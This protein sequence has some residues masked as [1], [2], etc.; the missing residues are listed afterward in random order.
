MFRDPNFPRI[1][2]ATGGLPLYPSAIHHGNNTSA[3]I[4][5]R[6]SP[7]VITNPSGLQQNPVLHPYSS[8]PVM[9]VGMACGLRPANATTARESPPFHDASLFTGQLPE[10]CGGFSTP[11]PQNTSGAGQRYETPSCNNFGLD[12]AT[13]KNNPC[14]CSRA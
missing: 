12:G 4:I 14:C 11:V 6:P 7:A 3:N 8:P 1:P 2:L 13:G 5:N 10:S 9:N